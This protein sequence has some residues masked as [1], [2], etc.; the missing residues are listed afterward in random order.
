MEIGEKE[1]EIIGGE[2]TPEAEVV[3]GGEGQEV[4]DQ[5]G[6]D[7]FLFHLLA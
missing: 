5:E 7:L 2:T 6:G 1:E 3:S 4:K